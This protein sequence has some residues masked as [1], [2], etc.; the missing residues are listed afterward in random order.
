[1]TQ[2]KSALALFALFLLWLAAGGAAAENY[3]D[4]GEYVIHYNALPT[5]VLDPTIA[6]TY[7]I[8]RSKSRG[9]LNVAVLKKLAGTPGI[10]VSASVNAFSTNLN[11]QINEF[12]MREVREQSAI[13]YIGEF[14]VSNKETLKFTIT[15]RPEKTRPPR[16][17]EF[18]RQ[19]YVD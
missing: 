13:Y 6:R 12:E 17:V 16:T 1:M 10:P 3:R 5:D 19:F 15:V 2:R 9:M 14:N 11:S 8:T 7:G 18:T 4:V